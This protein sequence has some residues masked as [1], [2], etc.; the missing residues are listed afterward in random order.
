MLVMAVLY[1][2]CVGVYFA[3]QSLLVIEVLGEENYRTAI[4]GYYLVMGL[5][6]TVAYP[7]AG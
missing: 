2:L 4:G 6:G 5:S 1:G 3:M 7:V